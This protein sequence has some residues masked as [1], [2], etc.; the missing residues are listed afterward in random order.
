M[1][2]A[3]YAQT[4]YVHHVRNPG[5]GR[6]GWHPALGLGGLFFFDILRLDVARGLRDG[7]WTFGVDVNRDF[8][9]VL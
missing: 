3:P 7:R 2:L 8:W 9:G 5:S 1:T 4:L 6:E